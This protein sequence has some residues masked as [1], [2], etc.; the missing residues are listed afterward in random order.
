MCGRTMWPSSTT[1]EPISAR[2][3]EQ[4]AAGS[5]LESPSSGPRIR[6]ATV[7]DAG[8]LASVHLKT[9]L[10]AY[11]AIIPPDAPPPT[12]QSLVDE[13]KAAFQDPSFK[14]FLA[15]DHGKPVG[16]VALRTD[17]DFVGFGQLRRLYV[18]PDRW[19]RGAGS[20]LHDAA[21]AAL[22]GDGYRKAGLWVLEA[23]ARARHF[24]EPGGGAWCQT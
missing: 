5:G 12:K 24:Y 2:G 1:T 4:C 22:E 14:A 10:V 13:W 7:A 19:G 20:A 3:F 8:A 21:S 16:T 23:N 6:R 11:A 15:E 17:P 9:V 18:L